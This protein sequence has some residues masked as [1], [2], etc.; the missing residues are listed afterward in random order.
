MHI[1]V[2]KSVVNNFDLRTIDNKDKK[3][4]NLSIELNK[5]LSKEKR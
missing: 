1:F 4:L 3:P 5:E 2:A